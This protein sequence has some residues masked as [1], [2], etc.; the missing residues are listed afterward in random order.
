MDEFSTIIVDIRAYLVR[1]DLIAN[2]QAVLDYVNRGGT[3][4]V[5]YQKTFEWKEEFAPYPLTL[6]RNRVTREDAPITLLEPMHALFT[7]PNVMSAGDWDGWR[8]ERGLYFPS[9]WDEAYT[10][11]IDVQDPGE[12]N[13]PGSLLVAEY[14]EGVYVY[15]AL[16]W[17]RQLRELHPGTVRMF[18]NML[19]L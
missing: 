8:Q 17:Y 4:L 2:N 13:P 19:A 1:K 9:K 15:T 10:P 11:L 6:S 3:V 5:M 14:G 7:M 18:A 12:T 16:G